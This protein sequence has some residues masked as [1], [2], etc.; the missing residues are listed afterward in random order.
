VFAPVTHKYVDLLLLCCVNACVYFIIAYINPGYI[1]AGDLYVK[2]PIDIAAQWCMSF[3]E[4]FTKT[5]IYPSFI[6]LLLYG[7]YMATVDYKNVY[8]LQ[9]LW[10]LFIGGAAGLVLESALLLS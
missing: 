9:N 7:I 5:I 6:S 2:I 1:K 3:T 8:G 4:A 10:M